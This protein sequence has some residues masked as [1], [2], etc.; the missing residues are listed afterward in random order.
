MF[1]YAIIL[2]NMSFNVEYIEPFENI[3]EIS[4]LP[5]EAVSRQLRSN[6]ML[7]RT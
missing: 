1:M 3:G 5:T 6:A 4:L 2:F 7:K